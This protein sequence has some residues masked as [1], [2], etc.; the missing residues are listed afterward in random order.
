MYCKKVRAR[1][2]LW[3]RKGM[4][5]DRP[6]DVCMRNL[7]KKVRRGKETGSESTTRDL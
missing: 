3:V 5:C 7:P 1:G 6:M 2:F 4:E